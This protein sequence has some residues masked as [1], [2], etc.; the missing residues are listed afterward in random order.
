MWVKL[1]GTTVGLCVGA[2]MWMLTTFETTSASEQK[3]AAHNQAIMCS[4][5]YDLQKEIREYLEK[6]KDAKTAAD[7]EFYERQ[8]GLLRAEIERI[9]PKGVCR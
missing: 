2:V 4:T 6:H 7:K 9:D 5:I 8:I 1:T 3:W